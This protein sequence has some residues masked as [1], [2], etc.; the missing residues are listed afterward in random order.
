M[1]VR[2][3]WSDDENLRSRFLILAPVYVQKQ[4]DQSVQQCS[5]NIEEFQNHNLHL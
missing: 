4:F 2:Y 3:L 5:V 1:Q